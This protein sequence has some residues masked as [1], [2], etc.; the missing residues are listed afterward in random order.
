MISSSLSREINLFDVSEMPDLIASKSSAPLGALITAQ[1]VTGKTPVKVSWGQETSF[2][3][4]GE[5]QA[6]TS[7]NT[8]R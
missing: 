6:T 7:A 5:T 1:A 8:C 2:T 3:H 4:N